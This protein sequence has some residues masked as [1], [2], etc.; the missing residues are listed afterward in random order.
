MQKRGVVFVAG[1]IGITGLSELIQVCAERGI[2]FTVIWIVKSSGEVQALGTDLLWN[3][4]LAEALG[5]ERGRPWRANLP[6]P[7]SLARMPL[8]QIFVNG[9]K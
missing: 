3:H 5:E 6:M 4:C 2:P 9:H 8:F 1:G 7:F